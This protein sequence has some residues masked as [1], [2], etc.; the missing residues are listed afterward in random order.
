MGM[1]LNFAEIDLWWLLTLKERLRHK[2]STSKGNRK[3]VRKVFYDF[4]TAPLTPGH[5]A[6]LSLLEGLGVKVVPFQIEGEMDYA[7]AFHVTLNEFRQ[8]KKHFD[9]L[10]KSERA[11]RKA[12]RM[13]PTS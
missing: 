10:P 1:T 8:V 7:K 2:T 6:R 9:W 5:I 4:Q 12:A 11:S 13:S 3:I